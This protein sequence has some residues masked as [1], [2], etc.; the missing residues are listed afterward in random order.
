[1]EPLKLSKEKYKKIFADN[2]EGKTI[3]VFI[4]YSSTEKTFAGAVKEFLEKYGLSIFLAHEDIRPTV[5]WQEEIIHNLKGCDV[6]IPMVTQSFSI[7]EWTDQETGMAIAL[8]K[9]IVPLKLGKDPYGFIGRRQACK[10]DYENIKESCLKIIQV[11]KDNSLFRESVKDCLLRSLDKAYS[12]DNATEIIK[13]L[14]TFE[15]FTKDQANQTIR[16]S[17]RNNQ[18]RMCREGQ[19]FLE[20]VSKKYNSKI[21]SDLKG[22]LR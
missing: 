3:R 18:V 15:T 6:F 5:D 14:E 19:K 7:S 4:S 11:I 2:Y 8:D 22:G 10:F 9:F 1:M 20:L 17:I 13:E 12:F 21:D 16:I